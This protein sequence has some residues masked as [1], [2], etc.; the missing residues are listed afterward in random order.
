[1]TSFWHF[2]AHRLKRPDA[3]DS[4]LLAL[5]VGWNNEQEADQ[6][7]RLGY[8]VRHSTLKISADILRVI[9]GD[10]LSNRGQIIRLFTD[11]IR[12][13][14]FYADFATEGSS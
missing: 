13:T 3:S 11:W 7:V 2:S 6:L 8:T 5:S 10:L 12:F 14:Q 1:M 4:E 9:S